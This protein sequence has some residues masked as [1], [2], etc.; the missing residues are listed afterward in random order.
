[1]A[2][3]LPSMRGVF[4]GELLRPIPRGG[5]VLTGIGMQLPSQ[6]SASATGSNNYQRS[7]IPFFAPPFRA[8][9]WKFKLPNWFV[10]AQAQETD[11]TNAVGVSWATVFDSKAGA[12]PC[13]FAGDS[14]S[15][16]VAAG[17]TGEMYCP[18]FVSD[19]GEALFF[20]FE[21]FVNSTGSE[22]Y[23]VSYFLQLKGQGTGA[24][25]SNDLGGGREG[26]GAADPT[27]RL[28]GVLG[29][30]GASNSQSWGPA[31]AT[32][33]GWDGVTICDMIWGDSRL[34]AQ[35]SYDLTLAE[36]RSL[37]PV[38]RALVD[39]TGRAMSY[40]NFSGPGAYASTTA[41]GTGT[42]KRAAIIAGCDNPPIHNIWTSMNGN[43]I[44]NGTTFPTADDMK[45]ADA[46]LWDF[47]HTLA[48]DAYIYHLYGY[49]WSADA[50]NKGFSTVA[51]QAPAST[52]TYPTPTSVQQVVDDWLANPSDKPAYLRTFNVRPAVAD[53]TFQDR[54]KAPN[55]T[56]AGTFVSMSGRVLTIDFPATITWA[57]GMAVA[58][59]IN[60]VNVENFLISELTSVT[61]SGGNKRY[62]FTS[63][64]A[65]TKTHTAGD[66]C[67]TAFA[68]S[69]AH[70]GAYLDRKIATDILIPLKGTAIQSTFGQQVTVLIPP[71][72]TTTYSLFDPAVTPTFSMFNDESSVEVGTKFQASVA[73]KITALKYYRA[74]ADADN[75][76]VR[77]GHLWKSDGTLLGTVT[78]TTG[79][80]VSGW[81]SVDLAAPVPILANTTYVVSVHSD[82]N[83][84]ATNGGFTSAV[85][86]PGGR[87]TAL[88]D[89]AS[90]GNGVF[91]HDPAA[92]FPTDSFGASNYW[93]D[94]VFDPD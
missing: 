14:L 68:H 76:D 23:P 15:G 67:S 16:S 90:G 41:A 70:A 1:M 12:W 24:L 56:T 26:S 85:V 25:A 58:V 4:A 54:W 55:P 31:C 69:M 32:C 21:Y 77:N 3:I 91:V 81:Q 46:A 82:D 92:T 72:D 37:S 36:K 93:V 19:P 9:R 73:G 78:F 6:M 13:Y 88:A 89:G 8:N 83:Y 34:Y 75:T 65:A 48:P 74:P 18:Y 5:Q 11:G 79:P 80:G 51:D 44:N 30:G 52:A 57:P 49:P 86:G 29:T 64:N 61:D 27:K 38:S 84:L 50:N 53:A 60:T 10:S 94:V 63:Q 35:D 20:W 43:D 42:A 22:K 17:A 66:T 62:V 28:T 39:P 71:E 2:A 40:V 33:Y 87:L 59:S 45:T 7:K 47:F